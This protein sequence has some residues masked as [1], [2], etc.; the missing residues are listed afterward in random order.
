MWKLV[1]KAHELHCPYLMLVSLWL[2]DFCLAGVLLP[3]GASEDYFMPTNKLK[4]V[5]L[6]D[7]NSAR[8]LMAQAW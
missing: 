8:S 7:N 2:A 3:D 1:I 6:S 5:F 4:I